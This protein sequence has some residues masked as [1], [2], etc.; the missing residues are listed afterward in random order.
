METPEWT[1]HSRCSHQYFLHQNAVCDGNVVRV[2]TR[3][4][5]LP[6]IFKDGA[7]AQ[8][9]RLLLRN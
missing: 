4:F 5:S 6:E 7:T 9:T 1:V 2:L 3:L 8:K